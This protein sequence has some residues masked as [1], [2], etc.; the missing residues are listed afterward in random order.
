MAKQRFSAV[1]GPIFLTNP[2]ENQGRIKKKS[3]ELRIH[4]QRALHLS[5]EI[6]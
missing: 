1:F 2:L 4:T 3:S 5:G 6:K